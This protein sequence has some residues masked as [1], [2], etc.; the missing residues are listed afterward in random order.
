MPKFKNVEE[1]HE[2]WATHSGADY[3]DELEDITEFVVIT[4][5]KRKTTIRLD[6]AAIERIKAIAERRG[7]AWQTLMRSWVYERLEEEEKR[8]G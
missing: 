2:F 7:M 5:P 1:E 8:A 4:P 3:I 6:D